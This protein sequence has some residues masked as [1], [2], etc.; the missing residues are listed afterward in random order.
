MR[1][2]LDLPIRLP[3]ASCFWHTT[4]PLAILSPVW[5]N[6]SAYTY[7]SPNFGIT[8]GSL[9]KIGNLLLFCNW[10]SYEL[11]YS[12]SFKPS[13]TS[14]LTT[15]QGPSLWW[16]YSM[17]ELHSALHSFYSHSFLVSAWYLDLWRTWPISLI[18]FAVKVGPT[19]IL[20]PR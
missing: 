7:W 19:L 6:I 20:R 11:Y 10:S 8:F 17:N 3:L 16:R 13:S 9:S 18:I 15:V 14:S 4:Q 12:V 1:F 5:S 2:W